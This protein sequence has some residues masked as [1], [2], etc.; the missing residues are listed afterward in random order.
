MK[1]QPTILPSCFHDEIDYAMLSKVFQSVPE[2]QRRYGPA[3]YIG[4]ITLQQTLRVTP[5]MEAGLNCFVLPSPLMTLT[6]PTDV[7][8]CHFIR[9]ARRRAV[10]YAEGLSGKPG[11]PFSIFRC[12]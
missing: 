11:R 1:A 7:R 12:V 4:C 5:A 8:Y 6:H 3:K 2:G 10:I 9:Y